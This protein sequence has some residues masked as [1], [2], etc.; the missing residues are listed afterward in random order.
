[1]LQLRLYCGRFRFTKIPE[2]W[3]R[4]VAGFKYNG[5]SRAIKFEMDVVEN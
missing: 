4:K 3:F 2:N 5:D 1:M